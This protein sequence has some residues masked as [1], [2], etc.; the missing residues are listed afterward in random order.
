MHDA[1]SA[2]LRGGG[3]GDFPTT[4][5]SAVFGARSVDPVERA[6]S[7]R[8]LSRMYWK[9]IYK[10]VR[11]RWRKMPGD[12]EEIT[13][14][15]FLRSIDKNT[16]LGYESGR[17]RFRTFVRV[18][19]DR[20][21]VDLGRQSL[22]K[23]RGGGAR[24]LQLDF[25]AAEE[26]LEEHESPLPDPE[27][28][29]ELEWVKNLLELA[30]LGLRESCGRAGK[31]V[32]FR[33]FELFHLSDEPDRLSYADVAAKLGISVRDVNNRLTYARREFR[34]AVLEALRDSTTSEQ[35]MLEEARVVLGVG[36]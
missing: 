16:F 12:A 29:F 11:L 21:V 24:F 13:Q 8:V 32:H 31:D 3:K 27:K 17:A 7:L 20:L 6:R 26:E 28:L 18:C 33:A 30:V 35:E 2:V 23:K 25:K 19:V 15:F 22:A 1:R 4:P 9:P 10:Y 34:A 14:E 5:G 36:F